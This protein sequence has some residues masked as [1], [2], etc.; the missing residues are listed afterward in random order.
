MVKV[1]P[2]WVA[3]CEVTFITTLPQDARPFG[4]RADAGLY[5]FTDTQRP[6]SDVVVVVPAGADGVVRP[7]ADGVVGM[8]TVDSRSEP[9]AAMAPTA[10]TESNVTVLFMMVFFVRSQIRS[11]THNLARPHP[12]SLR[13]S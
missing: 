13:F 2:I 3:V 11:Q 8:R 10:S 1:P 6:T 12:E 9:Q 5:A 7:T 4:S